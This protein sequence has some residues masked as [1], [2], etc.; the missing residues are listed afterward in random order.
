MIA[1]GAEAAVCQL[2]VAGCWA[3]RSRSTK[4]NEYPEKASRPWDKDRDG[5][6]MG[7]GSGILVLEDYEHAK[8]MVAYAKKK[9]IFESS[10]VMKA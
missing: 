5:F 7:E 6:V 8:K 9:G 3:A 4:Y 1:G 10:N 2:G